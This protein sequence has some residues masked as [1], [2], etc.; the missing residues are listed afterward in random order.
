MPENL[1]NSTASRAYLCG[2]GALAGLSLWL[3]FDVL[4]DALGN[5]YLLLWI[6]STSMAFFG[7]TLG[8]SGYLHPKQALGV[9]SVWALFCGA[10][11]QWSS[12]RYFEFDDLFEAGFAPLCWALLVLLGAPFGAAILRRNLWDYRYLF[13]T[14]WGIVVRY[15]AG[16]I[17]LGLFWALIFLSDAL[18]RT[19]GLT[20]IQDL[21][22]I[23]PVP[24][25]LSGLVLGLALAVAQE[26][27]D[28]IS[29]YLVLRL[30]RLL[31]PL[32]LIVVA[33]FIAVLP[34]RGL[35]NLF[36]DFSAAAILMSVTLI[37]ITMITS[38]LDRDDQGAVA[39][40]VLYWS[41][42][43][44]ILA[45]PLLS[46][47]ALW[48]IVLRVEAYGWTP[49]RL[50]AALAAALVFAYAALYLV[51]LLRGARWMAHIRRSNIVM[52]LAV[53]ALAA[54]WMTPVMHAERIA[55]Q[56]QL[57]RYLSGKSTAQQF[58]AWEMQNKWG[59]AGQAVIAQLQLDPTAVHA[60]V[61]AELA[62]AKGLTSY[63]FERGN[64]E[65]SSET[66]AQELQGLVVVSGQELLDVSPKYDRL[67]NRHLKKWVQ[68][69]SQATTMKCHLIVGPFAD[70]GALSALFFLPDQPKTVSVYGLVWDNGALI[71][72]RA[73]KDKL[74]QVLSLTPTQ[75]QAILDG[76]HKVAPATRQSL[77]IGDLE[78]IANN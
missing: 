36:G 24:F 58:P 10:L 21:L 42:K 23:E 1:P 25:V 37:S 33:T 65:K 47:L 20:V 71:A 53:M 7:L 27:S 59:V 8:L 22:D 14:A 44:L 46:G 2:I 77:W 74:G 11:L 73:L 45:L 75:M 6:A 3:L 51:A 35:S 68:V 49:E 41:C 55:A 63:Q 16:F 5:Q 56:S 61:L 67:S 31:V 29:P 39:T 62:R 48:S 69:C 64:T 12:Q 13:D 9:A 19:V 60:A 26:L 57:A 70:Y 28:F 32:V 30:I 52:A 76:H 38:A 34:A 72:A 54:L 18:F 4:P 40:R 66:L 17:F 43:A 15:F 50:A 78:I